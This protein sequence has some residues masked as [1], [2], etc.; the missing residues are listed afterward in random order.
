MLVVLEQ[1]DLHLNLQLRAGNVMLQT[2]MM[3]F[4][5]VANA[6]ALNSGFITEKATEK[7]VLE[8]GTNDGS[9]DEFIELE[10]DTAGLIMQEQNTEDLL[11][12]LT[13]VAIGILLLITI[14]VSA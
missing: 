1:T 2:F 8:A 6:I 9:A 7:F 4:Q 12:L 11:Q 13:L 3:Y 10:G 14:T 5:S